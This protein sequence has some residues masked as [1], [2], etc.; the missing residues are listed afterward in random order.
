[1][2]SRPPASS[3]PLRRDI[4]PDRRWMRWRSLQANTCRMAIPWHG[5]HRPSSNGNELGRASC[6]AR[7]CQYV[8]ISVVAVSLNKTLTSISISYLL[9]FCFLFF[10]FSFFSFLSFHL[11]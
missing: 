10:F 6:R 11:L 1:M 3:A 4:V 2:Y 7:V 8:S 9:F 5:A